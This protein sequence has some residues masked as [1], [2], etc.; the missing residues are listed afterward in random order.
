MPREDLALRRRAP[1]PLGAAVEA[2]VA[3]LAPATTLARVQAC[4][5]EA[6]G[7]GLAAEAFPSSERDGIV[8]ISCRSSVWAHELSLLSADLL[9]RLSAS[10]EPGGGGAPVRGL[11]FVATGPSTRP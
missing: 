4:W 1:R 10:L 2:L 9:A 3:D 6:V 5:P 11:R 7:P 8:T